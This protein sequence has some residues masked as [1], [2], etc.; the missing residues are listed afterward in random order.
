MTRKYGAKKD[1]NHNQIVE[2]FIQLGCCVHDCSSVGGGVPDLLVGLPDSYLCM[3]VEIKNPKTGYGRRGLNKNQKA[4]AANWTGG[5]M[6]VKDLGDVY[7]VVAKLKSW[8]RA[9]HQPYV[10]DDRN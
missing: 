7:T 8:H 10:M 1:A 5:L 2:E 3:Y 6:V 4:F 9:I